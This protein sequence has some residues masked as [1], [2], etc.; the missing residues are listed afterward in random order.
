MRMRGSF[1]QDQVGGALMAVVGVAVAIASFG[2]GIGALRSMGSGFFPLVL[3]AGLAL[4]GGAIVVT[5]PRGRDEGRAA[6]ASATTSPALPADE[7]AAAAP[8]AAR[9]D[10]R[11]GLC[12]LGA[13]LA[14]VLLG[15]HGGLVPAS[16][17]CV[18]VAAMG[19]RSNRPRDALGLALAM[20][21]FATIVF[22]YGLHVLLPLFAW[23]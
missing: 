20:T 11:G 5:A 3:G 17:A 12:I 1:T 23:R 13:L 4:V 22:H 10:A 2:Y 9:L 7:Q 8:R 18:F 19:D 14:F 15:D 21:A 16:F 6:A